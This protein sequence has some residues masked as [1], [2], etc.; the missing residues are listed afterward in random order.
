[1]DNNL[2]I[3]TKDMQMRNQNDKAK[4]KDSEVYLKNG[5]V[6]FHSFIHRRW[7]IEVSH[8]V[9]AHYLDFTATEER[10]TILQNYDQ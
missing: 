8:A 4:W 6:V 9:W 3:G 2:R 1:M 10:Q 7:D 5:G